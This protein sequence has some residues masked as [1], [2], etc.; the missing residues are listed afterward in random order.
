MLQWIEQLGISESPE[1]WA[2][3]YKEAMDHMPGSSIPFLQDDYLTDVLKVIQLTDKRSTLLQEAFKL[4]REHDSL[5]RLA[6]LWHYMI[7]VKLDSFSERVA[8]WPAPRL[9]DPAMETAQNFFPAVVLLSGFPHIMQL[10]KERNIPEQVIRETL[11]K[12]N[13]NMQVHEEE[14]GKTGLSMRLLNW[15]LNHFQGR[16]YSLGRLE[17]EMRTFRYPIRGYRNKLDGSVAALSE[18][19]VKYR[20]DGLV[21]GTNGICDESGG[22]TAYIREDDAE[23]EG[24]PLSSENGSA[25]NEPVALSKQQWE[26]RLKQ[27]DPVLH[28]HIP[29]KGSFTKEDCRDSFV[30]AVEFFKTYYPDWP[31]TAIACVSWLMDPQLRGLLGESSNLVKFQEW[32]HPYPVK[33]GDESIYTFVFRC[34]KRELDQLPEHTSLQRKMKDFMRA[35]G[36]FRLG[37][38]FMLKEEAEALK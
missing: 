2:R 11:G 31:Y 22:W 36:K 14:S 18:E 27:D 23:V 7:Y 4:M 21:D 1:S 32:Y 16:L 30:R 5:S 34:E 17:F 38:G 19:G 3:N 10:Y 8:E 33:S 9:S 28:V 20:R 35:G 6:W 12:V 25:L 29:R 15:L 24:F 13:A 26:L 37:G